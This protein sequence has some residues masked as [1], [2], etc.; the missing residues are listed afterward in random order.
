MSNLYERYAILEAESKRL[1]TEKEALR[2]E[3]LDEMSNQGEKKIDTSV[4]SFSISMLKKYTYPEYVLEIGE[5][6]KTA[7]AKTE[8]TGEATFE[9]KPSLR[10]TSIKF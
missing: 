5:Q 8:Q 3:I 7:K 6:F 4:G 10:F 9:E 1:E 2:T